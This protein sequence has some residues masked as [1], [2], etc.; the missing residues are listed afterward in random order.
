M[1]FVYK[2]SLDEYNAV[3]IGCTSNIKRRKDQHNESARKSRYYFGKFL[4]EHGIFLKK[5]DLE[6]IAT[7][8]NR[9]DAL[10]FERESTYALS[11]KDVL[12][13][14]DLYSDHC[15]KVG[16]RG[17][18]NPSSKVYVVVDTFNHTFDIVDDMHAWCNSHDG[19]SY[20]TLIGTAK[21]R[22]YVHKNRYIAR[23]IEEWN[24]IS[25]QE[26]EDLISGNWYATHLKLSSECHA[27]KSSKTYI[28]Q[29]P[30]GET[31]KVHNLDKFARE[32]GIN[33]GNLHASL[34]NGR[35][36]SGYKVLER[37]S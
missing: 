3:Y 12:V 22:P 24:S 37:L 25:N 36:A 30:S 13:L 15:S 1:Y 16:L 28:V 18:D 34:T 2:V 26:K 6:I 5:S 32:H 29:T 7:F 23:D 8:E 19:T 33:D 17:K 9:Q 10:D 35:S 11:E 14:N 4:N 20:K 31:V 27:I 21:R